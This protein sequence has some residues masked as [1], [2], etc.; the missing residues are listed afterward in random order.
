MPWT[1]RNR[2]FHAGLVSI[3][4]LRPQGAGVDRAEVSQRGL[5]ASPVRSMWSDPGSAAV[6][7]GRELAH[8]GAPYPTRLVM[9]KREGRAALH[10]TDPRLPADATFSP[11]LRDLVSALPFGAE[12]RLALVG[13]VLAL[14]RHRAATGL[15]V[16]VSIAHGFGYALFMAQPPPKR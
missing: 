3:S 7:L 8:S 11:A 12:M 16:A 10:Q 5:T 4:P 1:V 2:R 15:L 9:D 13:L 6:R 14:R